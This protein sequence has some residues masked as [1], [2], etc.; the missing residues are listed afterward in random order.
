MG[1]TAT[2]DEG[3]AARVVCTIGQ[4][5]VRASSMIHFVDRVTPPPNEKEENVSTTVFEITMSLDGFVA[6]PNATVEE[7]LGKGGESLHEWIVAL[8]SWQE[9]HGETGGARAG[10]EPSADEELY[11]EQVATTGAVVMGRR[12]F[13]GGEGAWADD[14]VSDGWWGDEPPFGVQVF[15]VT[16]HERAPLVKKG[17]TFHFVS[18]GIESAHARAREAAGDR[19]VRVAGGASVGGQL[20]QAGLVDEL[21]LHIAPT[22]LGGGVRLFEGVDFAALRFDPVRVSG[23]ALA[24]HIRYR[25]LR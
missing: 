3:P 14:P 5:L 9:R 19:N 25:V 22:L 2:G 8:P 23:S 20:L 17:T 13:S 10:A 11:R 1:S 4:L 21:R 15:V 6:G 18:D 12:M 16:H 24:T 7:P